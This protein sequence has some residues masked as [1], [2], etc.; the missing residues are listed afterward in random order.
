MLYTVRVLAVNIEMART[1]LKA[2]KRCCNNHIK[3]KMV[4]E[5]QC[6]TTLILWLFSDFPVYRFG[7]RCTCWYF[8]VEGTTHYPDSPGRDVDLYP[9]P[10]WGALT[11]LY[12][13]VVTSTN[14]VS[15]FDH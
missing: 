13:T 11:G 3:C 4:P 9:T 12:P 10:P 7:G 8:V 2:V 6:C 1:K 14:V 15:G 5:E